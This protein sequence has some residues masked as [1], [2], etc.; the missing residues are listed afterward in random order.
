[1]KVRIVARH[2]RKRWQTYDSIWPDWPIKKNDRPSRRGK[3]RAINLDAGV[4]SKIRW[5]KSR[6]VAEQLEFAGSRLT[7]DQP[8][9]K[10]RNESSSRIT[11]ELCRRYGTSIAQGQLSRLERAVNDNTGKYGIMMCPAHFRLFIELSWNARIINRSTIMYS[12]LLFD[13]RKSRII[14]FCVNQS[15]C[16]SRYAEQCNARLDHRN[17]MHEFALSQRNA[18]A[19]LRNGFDNELKK[20]TA[21]FGSRVN[22]LFASRISYRTISLRDGLHRNLHTLERMQLPPC[23][24]AFLH[25]DIVRLFMCQ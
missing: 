1:M 16:V 14:H 17:T 8:A 25:D 10:F 22:F 6:W 5:Q 24:R 15:Y 11:V 18:K 9:R 13:R 3:R 7:S 23:Q 12:L 2:E 19:E 20:S 4:R 21:L